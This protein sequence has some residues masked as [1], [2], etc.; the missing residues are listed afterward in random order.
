MNPIN[1]STLTLIME[2]GELNGTMQV[3]V[4]HNSDTWSISPEKAGKI[5]HT[6]LI[7]LPT[8]IVLTVSGKNMMCDTTVDS[9][10]KITADKYVKL[11]SILI[12]R[13]P[14]PAIWLEQKL[15]LVTDP[16]Q[17]IVSNYFGHNGTCTI[18]LPKPNA[19]LQMLSFSKEIT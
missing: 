10:G 7:T 19:F 3:S 8:E 6:M 9:T 1:Q 2:F 15:T 5:E 18:A 12:D 13:M 14:V 16:H 11:H 4:K 17:S